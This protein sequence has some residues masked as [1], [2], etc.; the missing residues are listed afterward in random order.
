MQTSQ[1]I[2]S[3]WNR[4]HSRVFSI[5]LYD[6]RD[7][8]VIEWLDSQENKSGANRE[9]I[10]ARKIERNRCTNPAP[11]NPHGSCPRFWIF[12]SAANR[13]S[14]EPAAA[15]LLSL[16]YHTIFQ[17][18]YPATAKKSKRIKFHISYLLPII[19]ESIAVLLQSETGF[20]AVFL[21]ICLNGVQEAAGSIPVTRTRKSPV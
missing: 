15:L 12:P 3:K 20:T 5:R 7:A 4:E 19:S 16:F 21:N 11:Q 18:F 1:E 8:D 2:R 17:Y 10:A 14:R 9:R 13:E 6:K